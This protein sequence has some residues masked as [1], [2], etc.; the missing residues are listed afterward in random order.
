MPGRYTAHLDIFYGQNGNQSKEIVADAVFWLLPWWFIIVV[1]VLLA[2]LTGG[3]WWLQRKL[4]GIVK[5]T[6]YKSGRGIS[7]RRAR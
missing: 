1:V 7:R 3:I 4:R 2:A 5:G 6:A